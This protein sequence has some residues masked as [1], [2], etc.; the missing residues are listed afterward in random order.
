MPE[1]PSPPAICAVCGGDLPH[2]QPLCDH[3][4]TLRGEARWIPDPDAQQ[5]REQRIRRAQ[6]QKAI[7]LALGA[8]VILVPLIDLPILRILPLWLQVSVLILAAMATLAAAERSRD[9]RRGRSFIVESSLPISGKSEL[10]EEQLIDGAGEGLSLALVDPGFAAGSSQEILHK[11]P[12]APSFTL[13]RTALLHLASRGL[14]QLRIERHL[15]WRRPMGSSY[16]PRL[17]RQQLLFTVAPLPS[18]ETPIPWLERRLL[19]ALESVAG[20]SPG[21]PSALSSSPYRGAEFE[22][23]VPPRW[24]TLGELLRSFHR[25]ESAQPFHRRWLVEGICSEKFNPEDPR[26]PGEPPQELALLLT[27]N[28]LRKAFDQAK[29][30][31]R[32]PGAAGEG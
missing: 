17:L 8:L 9:E 16:P 20:G 26:E 23:A 24:V 11:T 15:T 22:P 3:G 27:R 12:R 6:H 4:P 5:A 10:R 29:P 13:L 28:I 14:L 25:L 7:A 1:D 18:P 32:A 31:A 30:P 2:P 21:T 19:A